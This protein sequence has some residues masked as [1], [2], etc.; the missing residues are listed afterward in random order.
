MLYDD[1]ED[2]ISMIQN[3]LNYCKLNN[4]LNIKFSISNKDLIEKINKT[5]N[6]KFN[7]FESFIYVKNLIDEN[8][9]IRKHLDK[10]QSFETYVSGDVLIK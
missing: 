3:F 1:I 9:I 6:C 8:L 7:N 4:I 5:F 10:I 2:G